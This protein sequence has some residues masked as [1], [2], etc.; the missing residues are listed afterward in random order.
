MLQKSRFALL[1]LLTMLEVAQ[2][3][4]ELA[5][6]LAIE[7]YTDRLSYR[8]GD[9]IA[10]HMSSTFQRYHVTIQRYGA[11]RETVWQGD[12]DNGRSYPVPDNASTHGC[13]WPT[14]FTLRVPDTW[15]SGYYEAFTGTP[16]PEDPRHWIDGRTMSF[17]VRPTHPGQDAR[18]LL[19]LSTNTYNAY[20]NWGGSSLYGFNSRDQRPAYRVSF[21]RPIPSDAHRWEIPFVEWAER[22]GYRLDY[23]VNSD[24]ERFP[25][26]IKPYRVIVSVGHDE[27]WSG[28]MRDHIEE[29]VANGGNLAFFGGNNLSWQI[30]YED[31]G[32]TMVC[33]KDRY[34][35]DPLYR[36]GGPNPLVTTLWSHPLVNRPENQLTGVGMMFGGMHRSQ[37]QLMNGSG[38][39]TVHRPDHWVFEATGLREGDAFG[40]QDSIVGY[41]TDGCETTVVDRRIVPTH[42]DGTPESFEIL[43]TAPARWPDDEWS[44]WELWP[45]GRAGNACLGL[46]STA[47][48]G[49]VFSAATT[50]WANG[51]R[52]HD[53]VIERITRNVLDRL[54]RG[55]RAGK[56]SVHD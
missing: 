47:G 17:V 26:L 35:E 52:G 41:E 43:A 53:P 3:E 16:D 10:F 38:A 54:S 15:Q 13:D 40:G 8:A 5:T 2:A 23:A 55:D 28:P 56:R 50:G 11:K 18:I 29:F 20:N 7:G 1:L 45:E 34:R 32:Q 22:I 24:L 19:Q 25:E 39:F 4:S 37:G 36:P 21:S 12:M 51:L 49:T 42:R 14:G 44:W 6:P 33:W 46:Y 30:R 9:E 27:Y 31:D 48:G